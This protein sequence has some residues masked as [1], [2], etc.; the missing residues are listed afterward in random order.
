MGEK[1]NSKKNKLTVREPN[2]LIDCVF[3]AI[4]QGAPE[5]ILERCTHIRTGG[6]KV[7][8]TQMAKQQIIDKIAEYGTGKS[9]RNNANGQCTFENT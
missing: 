9:R 2:N 1:P 4:L 6:N 3:V 5:S 8:L 7:P